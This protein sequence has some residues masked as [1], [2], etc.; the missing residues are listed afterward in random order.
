MRVGGVELR[1]IR[2]EVGLDASGRFFLVDVEEYLCPL[3]LGSLAAQL[4][5]QRSIG[6]EYLY[7]LVAPVGD[8]DSARIVNRDAGR[9][10][11]FS[12][13][14]TGRSVGG[15]VFAV[16]R[17][18]LYPVIAPVCDVDVAPGLSRRSDGDAP[19]EV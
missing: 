9:P 7:S 17:E 16:G 13:A 10:A 2:I 19:R 12:V 4:L 6:V 5:D 18:P 14:P 3:R 15:Y 11:Q 8:I 1:N